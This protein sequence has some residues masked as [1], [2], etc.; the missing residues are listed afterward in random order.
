MSDRKYVLKSQLHDTYVQGHGD[1][2]FART[3]KIDEALCFDNIAEL[4]Q[5]TSRNSRSSGCGSY[6][7]VRVDFVPNPRIVEVGVVS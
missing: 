4:L 2:G 3:Y 5:F 7:I 6:D 1:N